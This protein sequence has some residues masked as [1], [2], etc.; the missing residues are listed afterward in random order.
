MPQQGVIELIGGMSWESSAEYYRTINQAVRT[1]L[2][3]CTPRCLMW[4]L[5]FS[6]IEALQHAGCWNDAA[7][8][9]VDAAQRLQRGGATSY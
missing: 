4:S 8:L 5:G 7:A 3:V 2:A 9:L 1:G 6:K